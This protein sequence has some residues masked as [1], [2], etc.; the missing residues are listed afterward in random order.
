VPRSISPSENQLKAR[1]L[2]ELRRTKRISAATVIANELPLGTTGVRADLA[3]YAKTFTGVEIKSDRDSLK[4][5]DHQLPVYKQ[6]FDRT[7]LLVGSKHVPDLEALDLHGIEIWVANGLSLSR[8]QEGVKVDRAQFHTAVLPS[9][10]QQRLG[11]LPSELTTNRTTFR[12]VFFGRF[13]ST[14]EIFW[15]ATKD[16]TIGTEHLSMLSRFIEKRNQISLASAQAQKQREE[17]RRLL[18]QSVHSSSV[19]KNDTSSS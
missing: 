9:Y 1:L 17:W 14:S 6:H 3:F 16:L 12:Q 18:A 7:I 10:L 4:R 5:L 2:N 19:S 15:S 11:S 13:K 8:T